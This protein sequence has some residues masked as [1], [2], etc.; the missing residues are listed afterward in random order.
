ML[1]QEAG[2]PDNVAYLVLGLAALAVIF[3]AGWSVS[4]CPARPAPR[5]GLLSEL[6]AGRPGADRVA[7]GT[8]VQAK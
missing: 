5:R 1:L 7:P 2:I 6:E 3:G 8:P 4:S